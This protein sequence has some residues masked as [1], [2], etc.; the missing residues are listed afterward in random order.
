MYIFHELFYTFC[1]LGFVIIGF[2]WGFQ[3]GA[4]NK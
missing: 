3:E 1:A 4:K 2:A